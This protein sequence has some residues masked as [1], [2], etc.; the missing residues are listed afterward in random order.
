LFCGLG[1]FT[2]PLARRVAEVTGVEGEHGL[3]MRAADNA[4]RNGIAN[5]N[6]QVANLFEDQRGTDWARKP[7]DKLLLDPP[8]AGADKVLEYLP[9]KETSRIVYVSCHPASLARDAGILV[10]QHSF[11]LVSAG[12]MDMFPHTAHVESIALFE[13]V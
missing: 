10:N 3:V 7:W 11:R 5:A 2:L 4:A 13:R 9:H 8:R 1:N 6:F 12:V